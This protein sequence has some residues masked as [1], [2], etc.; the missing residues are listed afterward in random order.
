MSS[1]RR[2][3]RRLAALRGSG[4]GV[5]EADAAVG[6]VLGVAGGK[7]GAMVT[8]D[9]GDESVERAGWEAERPA[10]GDNFSVI[11]SG[12]FIEGEN[13]AGEQPEQEAVGGCLEAVSPFSSGEDLDSGTNLGRCD[14]GGKYEFWRLVGEPGVNI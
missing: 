3:A 1:V 10:A 9:G 13:S 7:D 12:R 14:G 5:D 6:E 8:G 4:P 11:R 2:A